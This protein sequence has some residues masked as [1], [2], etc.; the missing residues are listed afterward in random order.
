MFLCVLECGSPTWR[1]VA[2][3]VLFTFVMCQGLQLNP[4]L[5][6]SASLASQPAPG[7]PCVSDAVIADTWLLCGPNSTPWACS[8]QFSHWVESPHLR[9]LTSNFVDLSESVSVFNIVINWHF[10][11]CFSPIQGGGA[12]KLCSLEKEVLVYVQ[13]ERQRLHRHPGSLYLQS[14]CTEGTEIAYYFSP[15]RN[16]N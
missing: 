1:Q 13:N 3:E 15:F 5:A 12:S 9:I 14:V 11:F 10:G 4:E 6:I 2:P 16:H 8:R 7:V